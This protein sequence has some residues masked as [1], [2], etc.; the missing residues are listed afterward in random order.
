MSA[1]AKNRSVPRVEGRDKVTGAAVYTADV[2]VPGLVH[3][4][5]VQSRIPRGRVT[6][7]SVRREAR[8]ASAAPGVLHV[9]TPLN[10]PPLHSLPSDLTADFPFERRT[11][12]ADLQVHYAGQHMALVVADT[13]ENATAAAQGMRL[14]YET[15]PAHLVMADVPAADRYRPDHW[16][17]LVEEKLQD[18]RGADQICATTDLVPHHGTYHTPEHAHHPIELSATI[19]EWAGEHLTVHDT[20]RWIAG[21]RRVLACYLGMPEDRVRVVS[22]LVGGAFGSKNFLWMH[23][24]LCAVAARTV[25]RPVKLVLTRDQM[26]TSTGHRPRTEQDLTLVADARGTLLSTEH[27][28]LT[29]TSPLAHFCE[30]AGL[31]ARYLYGSPRLVTSHTVAPTNMPTPCFMRGPGEAPGL[32]ALESAMDE[33]AYALG[34]DPVEFRVRNDADID[35][36]GGRPWS[37]KHLQECYRRGAQ[38]FGWSL[39]PRLPRAMRRGDLLVG[40]GMATATYPGRRMSAGCAVH[41]AVDGTVRFASATHEIGNG[42]R[43]VMGQVAAD[44]TGLP[45]TAVAFDTGDSRFPAAPYTGA[46]QTTASVGSAVFSAGVEWKQRLLSWVSGVDGGSAGLDIRAGV[47]LREGRPVVTVAEVLRDGGSELADLLTFTATAEGGEPATTTQSFGVHFCEVEVDEAIGKATVTRWSA[48]LDCG[49][50]VNPRLADSQVMGGVIFGI[51]MALF[52]QVPHD[53][54][55]RIGEYHVAT[56]ADIPDFDIEFVEVPDHDLDPI[57]VRGIGEIGS[58]GVA[59]AIA[60]AIFHATG[61]RIRQVPIT[62]E[63]LLG[64]PS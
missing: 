11:P 18:R 25:G 17:K 8:A 47:V 41:T 26:F 39:R 2:D 61:K 37:G 5:L 4:A 13:P 49:R 36:A 52:E 55:L 10:C 12:L 28:T 59:A 3:A 16:V 33:L 31:P 51:G 34:I 35:Q 23:V 56:H 38:R 15:A 14:D 58:S 30:P 45:L 20:T 42:V 50:V 43:T 54:G 62:T 21:E 48:T 64:E 9:L 6:A 46:S 63:M 57:G 29:E 1:N 44:A 27:H 40:W 32:F 19:A 7:E 60:N 53:A 22:P 24:V